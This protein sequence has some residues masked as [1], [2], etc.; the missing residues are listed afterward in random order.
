MGGSWQKRIDAMI[1]HQKK[2][3]WWVTGILL[4]AGF[5][6]WLIPVP[7]SERSYS[8]ALFDE[9]G[10]LIGASMS[11]D[12]QWCFPIKSKLPEKRLN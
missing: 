3:I 12:E 7:Q 6:F 1:R 11:L 5:S 9:E 2:T 8:T 10:N 4:F